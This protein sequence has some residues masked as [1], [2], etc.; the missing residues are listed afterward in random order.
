MNAHR[1]V[2]GLLLFCCATPALAD[3]RLSL[4]SARANGVVIFQIE[5]SRTAKGLTGAWIRPA[6]LTTDADGIAEAQGPVVRR[7]VLAVNDSGS[8]IALTVDDP[9]PNHKPDHLRFRL[10]DADHATLQINDQPTLALTRATG[11]EAIGPAQQGLVYRRVHPTNAEMTAIFN[12]DQAARANWHGDTPADIGRIVAEDRARRA[13]TQMLLDSGMLQS[14]ADY[15][16][17]AF[18]FQH[19]DTP[20]DYLKAHV[21]ATI[22]VARG[23]SSATWIAAATLDRYLQSTGQPQIF[24]TQFVGDDKGK[25]SQG[26]YNSA[27][28]ADALRRAVGVPAIADQMR[29]Q[30]RF[31]QEADAAKNKKR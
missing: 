7:A 21:L 20:A 8:D 26:K 19:G 18:L 30:E 22:A 13:Q 9:L 11:T 3:D 24:G 15:E 27:L 31:Q 16:N 1:L 28:L 23:K 2:F 25:V 4:W 14:G 29:R 12:A 6:E 10:I 5:V 17:A